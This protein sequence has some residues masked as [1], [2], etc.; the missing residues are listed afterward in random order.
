MSPDSGLPT[1]ASGSS[2]GSSNND[3]CITGKGQS[4]QLA[5]LR[6]MQIVSQ[7]SPTGA[8]SY[9]QGLEWAVETGWIY[10]INTF[11]SWVREQLQGMLA[12]Q[13]LPLM[14]R[15]YRAFEA[16]VSDACALDPIAPDQSSLEP[17]SREQS[18]VEPD[19]LAPAAVEYNTVLCWSLITIR[20]S[21][22]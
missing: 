10:D 16:C 17:S 18:F 13:E 8:F 19:A 1:S 22:E 21:P 15:F 6:L 2:N 5:R 7:G 12:Q 4:S 9:S 3:G 20:F 11:E 14:L